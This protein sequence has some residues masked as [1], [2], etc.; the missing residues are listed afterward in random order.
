MHSLDLINGPPKLF[1]FQKNA[2]KTNLGGFLFIVYIIISISISFTYLFDYFYDLSHNQ[3]YEI[4]SSKIEKVISPNEKEIYK[5]DNNLNP[6]IEFSFDLKNFFNSISLSNN[7]KIIDRTN[8]QEIERNS[9]IKKRVSD[10]NFEIR[11]Y[12]E[13]ENCE[14]NEN[15][16]YSSIYLVKMK[17]TGINIEHQ[18]DEIPLKYV[19]DLFGMD[20]PFYFYTQTLRILYWETIKYVE[21]SKGFFKIFDMIRGI[22]R[23]YYAGSIASNELYNFEFGFNEIGY[24]K[25]RKKYYKILGD[26]ILFNRFDYYMEYKRIKKGFLDVLAKI[27]ALI[28]SLYG[29]LGKLFSI[30]YSSSFDN[31]KIIEK[32]LFNK[33]KINLF[34]KSNKN[35]KE[36]ELTNDISNP[37]FLHNNQL[38]NDKLIINDNDNDT[39]NYNADNIVNNSVDNNYDDIDNL[40]TKFPKF[41]FWDFLFNTFYNKKC[42]KPNNKNEFLST[43]NQ[44]LFKY[45][46]IDNILYNQIKIENLLKDYKWNDP[47]LNNIGNNELILELKKYI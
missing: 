18:T 38:I 35:I 1:I 7:F 13:D 31:Y 24:D 25:E 30:F 32:I 9:I 41:R 26:V 42:F 5:S 39:D 12:C 37:D 22:N 28:T 2:N 3:K 36:I 33:K 23:T 19:N 8:S 43:C 17:F 10:A 14:L 11:Y 16:K 6:T 40:I 15:D 21:E 4:Q 45:I 34:E 47:Q 20:F 27:L 44:I 29:I 46:S